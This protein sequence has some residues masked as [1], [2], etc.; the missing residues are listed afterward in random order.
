M[1]T[2]AVMADALRAVYP[3]VPDPPP[4]PSPTAKG[5]QSPQKRQPRQ[6]VALPPK[7][8][9]LVLETVPRP[10][11][12][13]YVHLRTLETHTRTHMHTHPR[14][15]TYVHTDTRTTPLFTSLWLV[16]LR[17]VCPCGVAESPSRELDEFEYRYVFVLCVPQAG[18]CCG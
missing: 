14:T 12:E 10:R 18:E 15:H 17:P 7:P 1:K 13:K 11:S 3:K 5:R 16:W 9:P 8:D 4:P 2:A 6:I